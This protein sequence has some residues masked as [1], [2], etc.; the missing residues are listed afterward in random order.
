M[1]LL[2]V[3]SLISYEASLFEVEEDR[4]LEILLD[5][6]ESLARYPLDIN[7]AGFDDLV[8]ILYLTP[9]DC[10]NIIEYRTM[11]GPYDKTSDLLNVRG[12]DEALYD[13]IRP[14]ITVKAKPL[15]IEKCNIRLRSITELPR[16]ELSEKYYTRSEVKY[17][18]YSM[19]LI[20]EKDPFEDSF[21]DYYAVGFFAGS[22]VRRFAFGKYNLDLGSGVL[23]SPVGSFL[24]STDFRV[25]MRERGLFP[26]TSVLE[27]SGFFG[28]AYSD[29]LLL[30]YTIFVSQQKL[31]GRIDTLGFTR[32]FD[33]SGEHTDSLSRSRKDQINERLF[34]YDA[35]YRISDLQISSRSYWCMYD[36]PF[37]CA[38]STTQFYGD[39]FWTTGI[40]L[41]Y[42]AESFVIVSELA[43]SFRNRIGGLFGFNGQFSSFDVQLAGKYFPAQFYSPKGV[44]A[45]NDYVGGILVVRHRSSIADIGMT[46]S[47]DGDTE[48]DSA[49]YKVQFNFEKKIG[50]VNAKLQT[51]WRWYGGER[52][53][54]SSRAF[55][56][57]TPFRHLFFDIRLEDKYVYD[58]D[59]VSTGLFAAIEMG[60]EFKAIRGR[61][62]Y[63]VFDTDDYDARLYVYETDLPGVIKNRTLYD[64]GHYGFIYC[65]VKPFQSVTL[66]AKYSIMEKGDFLDKR[67]GAQLDIRL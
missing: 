58:I 47:I 8:K 22:D 45:D 29:S 44:E 67:V 48:T 25:I 10:L 26:Y 56:R 18:N 43:R 24:Y 40:G 14:F 2:L 36:P 37:V 55:L 39:K 28:A 15:R 51:R 53:Y 5:E 35:H 61:V 12:F 33:A 64:D 21:F 16:S 62:R 57:V 19:H 49:K 38:D 63:G 50:I 60:F 13:K 54:A 66:S 11:H 20:T 3:L 59:N 46:V 34:G 6:M 41:N 4:D 9:T 30:R 65:A 27:N 23:L 32:S 42:Y 7:T 52:D 17:G 31:D 1:T